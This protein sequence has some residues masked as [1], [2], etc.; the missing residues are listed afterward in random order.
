LAELVAKTNSRSDAHY[1]L[2]RTDRE[3]ERLIA[4]A[5]WINAYTEQT[6]HEVGIQTGMRV[7]DVGCGVG[8]VS[9]LLA[10]LVGSSGKVVGIDQDS[11]ALSK[12][13]Q[14]IEAAGLHTVGF[15]QGDFRT[16]GFDGLFDAVVGRYVLM[17]QAE[18]ILAIRSLLARMHPGALIAFQEL[19][20]SR[21]PICRPR[22]PLFENCF[23]W[24]L[25]ANR[26]ARVNV[27][28]GLDLYQT[29][30]ACGLPDTKLR[31]DTIVGAGPNFPGYEILAESMRSILPVLESFGIAS[32]KEVGVD[33]LAQRLRDA[34]VSAN[35]IVMWSPIISAWAAKP[36]AA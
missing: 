28:M 4:Q 18:P 8:D 15:V 9:L 5:R 22:I 27:R 10:R 30:V 32:A 33:T 13:R 31:M 24:G 7:L 3:Y 35:A 6:L 20:M 14:R 25:L 2:G 12:A 36:T 16:H 29:F 1:L 21:V 11:G 34:A 26:K 19:D 23:R 17:Y